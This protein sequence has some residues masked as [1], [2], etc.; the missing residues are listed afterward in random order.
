MGPGSCVNPSG[1]FVSAQLWVNAA[2]RAALTLAAG[3]LLVATLASYWRPALSADALGC[4]L[5]LL[6]FAFA[7]SG[8]ADL[9]ARER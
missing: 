7:M 2:L 4:S 8:S 5:T 3:S 6:A 1:T 9:S